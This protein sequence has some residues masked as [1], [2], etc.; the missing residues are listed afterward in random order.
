M[1]PLLGEKTMCQN[2]RERLIRR[3]VSGHYPPGMQLPPLPELSRQYGVSL[4]TMRRT[5]RSMAAEGMVEARQGRRIQI[6]ENF[7]GLPLKGLVAILID[8]YD[9]EF[10]YGSDPCQWHFIQTVQKNLFE[11]GQA[12]VLLP[13]SARL[14]R[15]LS[16]LF[17]SIVV[18]DLAAR[19]SARYDE[20]RHLDRPY[21]IFHDGFPHL[22][23]LS[24]SLRLEYTQSS[25]RAAIYIATSGMEHLVFCNYA[26][27]ASGIASNG[28]IMTSLMRELEK[29]GFHCRSMI[30]R[31]VP[32]YFA[33]SGEAAMRELL[34]AGLPR[35]SAIITI[36]D[37]VAAGMIQVGLEHGWRLK[38]DFLVIGGSGLPEAAKWNPAPSTFAPP[39]Y[40]AAEQAILMLRE[41]LESGQC[42]IP[43]RDLPVKFIVRQS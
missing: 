35:R 17:S 23:S 38:Q 34:S 43:S 6:A 25:A 10:R 40:E 1:R 22:A 28:F 42:R 18:C 33:P 12:S 19:F 4:S 30:E 26:P 21:V 31:T 37:L 5:L 41:Q 32:D 27:D 36:G 8:D 9:G 39:F 2:L 7:A 24:N 13:L 29:L 11:Q 15:G 20:F 3:I 16:E 14:T